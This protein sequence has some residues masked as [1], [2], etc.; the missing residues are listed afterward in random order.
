MKK[1]AF[2]NSL[3][4]ILCATACAEDPPQFAVDCEIQTRESGISHFV[5]FAC[6]FSFDAAVTGCGTVGAITDYTSWEQGI[7][8]GK[9]SLSP[10]GYGAKPLSTFTTERISACKP[11]Q[12]I[13]ETHA[14][15][16]ISK[17]VDNTNLTDCT[18]WNSLRSNWS[19]YTIGYI[20]C[21]GLWYGKSSTEPG[22]A[23][24][25]AGLGSVKEDNNDVADRYEANFTW[26]H[27]GLVCP[28]NIPNLMDAF[29]T[30][31]VS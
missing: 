4:L 19:K 11:E 1:S 27:S 13:G 26:K 12:I 2:L 9:I 10:E 6:D 29:K 17:A 20:G 21:D 24:T 14:M 3:V 18:Y 25:L 30:E 8:C 16:F 31:V 15:N 5:L 28:I 22:F 7:A 23:F